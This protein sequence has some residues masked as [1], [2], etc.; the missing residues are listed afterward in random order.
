M[1]KINK[2]EITI[3]KRF[4]KIRNLMKT[5]LFENFE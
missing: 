1:S 3:L 5:Q 2:Q 4:L